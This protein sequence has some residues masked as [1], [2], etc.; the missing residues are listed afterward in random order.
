[1]RALLRKLALVV[2]FVVLVLV[3]I[4]VIAGLSTTPVVTPSASTTT[5]LAKPT[6]IGGTGRIAFATHH[7]DK[8]QIYTIKSDGTGLIHVTDTLTEP[9]SLQWS[10]DGKH[11]AFRLIRFESEIY[12]VNAD[13]S[14]LIHLTGETGFDYDF[15]WSPDDSQIVYD[16]RDPVISDASIYTIHPDA[17]ELVQ[18]TNHFGS[19]ESPVWSPDGKRIAFVYKKDSVFGPFEIHVMNAMAQ[20]KSI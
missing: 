1:M 8:Y 10:H 19:Y 17:T 2:L 6:P 14:N 13:G 9:Q 20:G 16:S 3:A 5:T 4:R 18:L 7:D 15:A 11:L 12:V